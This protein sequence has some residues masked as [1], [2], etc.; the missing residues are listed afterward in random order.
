[1]NE[2]LNLSE[3]KALNWFLVHGPAQGD[4]PGM[5]QRHVRGALLQRGLIEYDPARK[6]FDPVSYVITEKGINELRGLS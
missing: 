3:R 6:R 2:P 5:P 1:M 4:A